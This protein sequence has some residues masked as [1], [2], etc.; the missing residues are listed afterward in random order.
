MMGRTEIRAYNRK[1]WDVAVERGSEWTVPVSP[2]QVEAARRGKWQIVLTPVRPVPASWF[3]SEMAGRDVLCLASGGGQQAPIL[4]AAG[5]AVTV[6]DNSPAQLAQDTRVARREGLSIRIIEG[7]MADLSD[8]AD[9][10]YDLVV[11]PASN[12]FV[13]DVRPVWR[14]AF[15][16]LRRGGVLMAGFV[17][18]A[19]YIFD[20]R[21]ADDGVLQVRHKLPY[22]DLTSVSA[23]ERRQYEDDWQPYEFGHTLEDQIGGQLAAGF[24]VTD[25]YEDLWPGT[26]LAEYMPTF[27]ATRALKSVE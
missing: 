24:V 20:Q 26:A 10:S 17:N 2:K 3:P 6:L 18:P 16:V 1:T 4:A 19:V 27:A 13:P 12:L 7:D 14:E 15:R 25:F 8:L 5:A 9:G 21:L 23:E 11:N 22:S